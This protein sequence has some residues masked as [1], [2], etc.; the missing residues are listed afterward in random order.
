M[1]PHIVVIT[2]PASVHDDVL[3]IYIK[4]HYLADV[5]LGI[6]TRAIIKEEK[7]VAAV[8][9]CLSTLQGYEHLGVRYRARRL[10][11]EEL[12]TRYG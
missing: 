9:C 8:E 6:G 12:L 11:S 3:T 10:G 4:S 1:A 2:I 5:T 7:V